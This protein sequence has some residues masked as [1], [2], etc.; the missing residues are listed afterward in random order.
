MTD[1]LYNITW[2]ENVMYKK[3]NNQPKSY[4]KSIL[5]SKKLSMKN[6]DIK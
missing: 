2:G 1:E 5:K 3:W 6:R 4:I